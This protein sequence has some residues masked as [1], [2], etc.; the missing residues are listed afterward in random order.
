MARKRYTVEQIIGKVSQGV[1]EDEE[2]FNG[3]PI[4]RDRTIGVGVSTPEECKAL[5]VS[6]PIARA[7]GLEWD[8]DKAHSAAY[9]AELTADMFCAAVNRF[10]PIYE[11]RASAE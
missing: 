8:A 5:G 2:L 1:S 7:A 6:G 3:N 10:R 4:F 9:D 11:S